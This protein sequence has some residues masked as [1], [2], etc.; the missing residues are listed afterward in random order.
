M[1]SE[2]IDTGLP[3]WLISLLVL[4]G[5]A[6]ILLIG[7]ALIQNVR[8]NTEAAPDTTGIDG[9]TRITPPVT[10]PAFTLTDLNGD[11]F[12][13]STLAGKTVVLAFGFANCPDICPLT[14]R[15]FAQLRENLGALAEDVQFVWISIDGNRDTPAALTTRFRQYAVLDDVIGLTGDPDVIRQAF[16]PLGLDFIYGTAAADGNYD[17]DHTSST[18]LLDQQGRWVM[19]FVF[20]TQRSLIEQAIREEIAQ[21]P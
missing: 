13:S 8:Q 19:R 21:T 4:L 7:I 3:R 12:N 20:G 18:F 14:L 16:A 15:Q 17:V 6:I 5:S 2:R 9:V 1:T 11:S 10:V